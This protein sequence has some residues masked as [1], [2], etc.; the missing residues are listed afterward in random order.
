MRESEQCRVAAQVVGQRRQ[1][2]ENRIAFQKDAE[3]VVLNNRDLFDT[4]KGR[5]KL[6]LEMFELFPKLA[7]IPGGVSIAFKAVNHFM[8]SRREQGR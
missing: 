4:T 1:Q 3:Q 6:M 2:I 5:G 7:D 8:K